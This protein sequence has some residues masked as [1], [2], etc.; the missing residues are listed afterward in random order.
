[1]CAPR[2]PAANPH[3]RISRER[4][5]ISGGGYVLRLKKRHE[6]IRRIKVLTGVD[7]YDTPIMDQLLATLGEGRA[8]ALVQLA[9]T[10]TPALFD[11]YAARKYRQAE[12]EAAEPDLLAD[13][14]TYRPSKVE[15][16][17]LDGGLE[18]AVAALYSTSLLSDVPT[19]GP[20][21]LSA[22]RACQKNL[23]S[24]NSN[25]YKRRVLDR[26]QSSSAFRTRADQQRLVPRRRVRSLGSRASFSDWRTMARAQRRS[27]RA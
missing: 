15:Q 18:L 25:V 22:R 17:Q 13:P 6:F 21:L 24:S 10:P 3:A 11:R 8:S 9:L 26:S 12:H 5:R 7:T 1:M 4:A 27:V 19:F 14:R 16:R 20:L 23:R 2:S